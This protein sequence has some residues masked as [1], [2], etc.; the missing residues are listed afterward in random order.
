[1][2]DVRVSDVSRRD[3]D[4]ITVYTDGAGWNGVLSEWAFVIY[5]GE[6][7]LVEVHDVTY[8]KHTNNEMEYEALVQALEYLYRE[9]DIALEYLHQHYDIKVNNSKPSHIGI[10]EYV[11]I[12]SDST[13]VV[14][15][16]AGLWKINKQVLKDYATRAN[17]L[18][19]AITYPV[20]IEWT[21][22]KKNRAGKLIECKQNERKKDAKRNQAKPNR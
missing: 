13:L 16:V 3:K 22:R 6:R 8:N 5:S 10:Y 14:N 20:H 9:Y 7:C 4:M 21:R 18:I 2:D 15:Q 11:V 19:A 17:H 1:L 12:R